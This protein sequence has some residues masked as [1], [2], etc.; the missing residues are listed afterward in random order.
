MTPC[1]VI[2]TIPSVCLIYVWSI[3][4]EEFLYMNNVFSLFDLYGHTPAHKPRSLGHE[5]Y[6]FG[7]PFITINLI[8]LNIYA[9]E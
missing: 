2:I 4:W 3:P 7:R 9:W 6:K 5:I 1:M 8:C